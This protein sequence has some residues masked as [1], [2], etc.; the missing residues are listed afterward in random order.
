[1]GDFTP[2]V[3]QASKKAAKMADNGYGAH[4][5]AYMI[6]RELKT[7]QSVAITP[8]VAAEAARWQQAVA[9]LARASESTLTHCQVAAPGP[10]WSWSED[11]YRAFGE[12]Q[13]AMAE[14]AQLI[15]EAKEAQGDA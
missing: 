15:A 2:G 4:D 1:M 13:A 12:L 5:F 11:Y 9:E 6:Q 14:H 7:A 8:A 10:Y 3:W